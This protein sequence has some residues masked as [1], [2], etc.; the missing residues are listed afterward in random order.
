[1]PVVLDDRGGEF[2]YQP[3]DAVLGLAVGIPDEHFSLVVGLNNGPLGTRL[4][5]E[6]SEP[7]SCNISQY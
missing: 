7:V 6:Q 3:V 1:M 5:N 2:F 4:V